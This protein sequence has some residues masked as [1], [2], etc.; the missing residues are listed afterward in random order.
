MA[1][2]EPL[3][4]ARQRSKR[5]QLWMRIKR[6]LALAFLAL[7]AF[8]LIKQARTIDWHE[9]GRTLQ[10]YP[11]P[12][13]GLAALLAA[14]S[15]G[16]YSCFDLLG[17]AYTGHRLPVLRSMAV[18]FVSYVFNLNLG[19]LIGG[20]AF[21]FRLYS[22]M[23]LDAATITRILGTSWA[24]NWLGYTG[25]A[26]AVFVTRSLNIP[27]DWAMGDVA[28]QALGAL[29]IAL[30]VGYLW[31]CLAAEQRHWVVHG[32]QIDLPTGQ[33]AV[34]QWLL[35]TV[36]WLVIAAIVYTLLSHRVPYPQ[37]LGVLLLSAVAGVITHVPAGLGVLEAVFIAM[38]SHLVPQHELL[39]ALLAY[40][41]LYYLAPL[42]LAGVVYARLE[43]K[44]KASGLGR[45]PAGGAPAGGHFLAGTRK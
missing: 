42:L 23:G 1:S 12:V 17:R 27:D 33:I 22:R 20:V 9:V 6:P 7:V 45:Q 26:G 24:T 15:H 16:I 11:A 39:A 40:R 2:S 14:A 3:V 18:A 5:R 43:A 28:L 21:R 36:N 32:H 31:T 13:L 10:A 29:F 30:V 35:S 41:A 8:L 4:L 25:L 38:L 19:S 37:V 44:A 34:M